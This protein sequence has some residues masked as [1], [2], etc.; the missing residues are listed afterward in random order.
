MSLNESLPA[1]SVGSCQAHRQLTQALAIVV[2]E[3]TCSSAE[4]F[5]PLGFFF[6]FDSIPE[7]R[8]YS[9]F[10]N[11]V[12]AALRNDMFG[13]FMRPASYR[14]QFRSLFNT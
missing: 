1:G 6:S 13:F 8:P 9:I 14:C 12:P 10:K 11:Y 4:F 5:H 3:N 7:R 2:I